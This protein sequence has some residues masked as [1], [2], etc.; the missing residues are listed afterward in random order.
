MNHLEQ[1][2]AE[3]FTYTGYFVRSN[4]KMNPRP[5]GGYDDEIERPRVPPTDERIDSRRAELGCVFVG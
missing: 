4:I 3:W 1:V 5:N 2:V